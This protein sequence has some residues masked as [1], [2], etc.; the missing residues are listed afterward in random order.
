MTRSFRRAV[1][2]AANGQPG[3]YRTYPADHGGTPVAALPDTTT[4]VRTLF[5]R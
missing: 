5:A 4:F 1:L 2:V 3:T